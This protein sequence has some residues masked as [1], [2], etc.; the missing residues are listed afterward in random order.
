MHPGKATRYSALSRPA[1]SLERDP[2]DDNRRRSV[3]ALEENWQCARSCWSDHGLFMSRAIHPR[4]ERRKPTESCIREGSVSQHPKYNGW[5]LAVG[6][7]CSKLRHVWG[8]C[9]F[10]H[11]PGCG[12]LT[13]GAAQR[14]SRYIFMF[15]EI[16][17]LEVLHTDNEAAA[18]S[19]RDMM[20]LCIVAF[21]VLTLRFP[22][23]SNAKQAC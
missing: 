2:C 8:P 9:P 12:A 19:T 5:A 3:E 7:R 20:R 23:I 1:F 6:V 22:T 14:P 16:A 11:G 15:L 4:V 10:C 21:L 13:F 18:P 17:M